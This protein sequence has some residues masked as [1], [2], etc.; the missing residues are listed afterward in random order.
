MFEGAE[1]GEDGEK[2][3]GR[4]AYDEVPEG[5]SCNDV[6]LVPDAEDGM[7]LNGKVLIKDDPATG[8]TNE[9]EI[10]EVLFGR[11]AT[12]PFVEEGDGENGDEHNEGEGREEGAKGG[13]KDVEEVLLD[14]FDIF[15]GS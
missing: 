1:E 2:K 14:G 10:P 7:V 15:C 6:L 8:V 9:D 3:K 12:N 5:N 13:E 11:E 4:E